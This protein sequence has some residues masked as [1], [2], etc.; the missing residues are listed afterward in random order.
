METARQKA[1]AFLRVA[2]DF[3]LGTLPTEQRH[4]QTYELSTQARN[5]IVRQARI[6]R[7]GG[8]FSQCTL[9][10]LDQETRPNMHTD[11]GRE[12]GFRFFQLPQRL[13]GL[14]S[15]GVKTTG[16][17][18]GPG[19]RQSTTAGGSTGSAAR[20]TRALLVCLVRRIQYS[21]R[22]RNSAALSVFWM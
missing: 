8:E 6:T 18:G 19:S 10:D 2:S 9:G 3:Q 15:V 21:K 20:N 11:C 7:R 1:E 14:G 16:F 12:M 17:D 13:D 4:P 5:D 22:L